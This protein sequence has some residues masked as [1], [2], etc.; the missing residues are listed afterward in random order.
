MEDFAAIAMRIA[1]AAGIPLLQRLALLL[2]LAAVVYIGGKI[3]TLKFPK[4]ESGAANENNETPSHGSPLNTDPE[5]P[6]GG[7]TGGMG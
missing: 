4:G 7:P 6:G 5:N 2:A 1:D 3:G